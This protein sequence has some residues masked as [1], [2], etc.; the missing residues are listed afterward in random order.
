MDLIR[1]TIE[2]Y[3]GSRSVTGGTCFGVSTVQTLY[4][5]QKNLQKLP[6]RRGGCAHTLALA[7]TQQ[8][9]V[10]PRESVVGQSTAV[11]AGNSKKKKNILDPLPMCSP[12]V[13]KVRTASALCLPVRQSLKLCPV[14]SG[15]TI[16]LAAAHKPTNVPVR[17]G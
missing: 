15:H 12:R 4:S 5:T 2:L 10:Q 13:R 6:P 8:D 11:R 16:Q 17:A 14:E 1:C 3:D 9:S 7:R